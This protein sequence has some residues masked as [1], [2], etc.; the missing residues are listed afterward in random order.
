M[1]NYPTTTFITNQLPHGVIHGKEKKGKKGGGEEKKKN[2]TFLINKFRPI[3]VFSLRDYSPSG[4]KRRKKKK[5]KEKKTPILPAICANMMYFY[6]EGGEEKKR[7][8]GKKERTTLIPYTQ[9]NTK[10]AASWVRAR[11]RGGGRKRGRKRRDPLKFFSLFL[12][13]C[14]LDHNVIKEGWERGK[15]RGEKKRDVECIFAPRDVLIV[16]PGT[17]GRGAWDGVER[18]GKGRE[19]G[20]RTSALSTSFFLPYL[21]K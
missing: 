10:L 4:I 13:S 12:F 18:G 11:E 16:E 2:P 5:K 9:T 3:R 19:K 15:K 7:E 1:A 6:Q 17:S 8:R 20:G 14:C 21:A